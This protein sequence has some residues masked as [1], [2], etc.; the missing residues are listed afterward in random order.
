MSDAITAEQEQGLTLEQRRRFLALPLE[1]RRR[2]MAE[3]AARVAEHY[4]SAEAVKEREV[5]QG[6]DL[7]EP[8]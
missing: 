2:Q 4:E 1:E 3:Q 6:G 7:V 8:S 5:W